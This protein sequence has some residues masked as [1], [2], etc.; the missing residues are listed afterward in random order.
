MGKFVECYLKQDHF[1]VNP[2]RFC[3]NG[4]HVGR[5]V[6]AGKTSVHTRNLLSLKIGL[7]YTL[8]DD[9]LHFMEQLP[10]WFGV[11]LSKW[12]SCSPCEV[13]TYHVTQVGLGTSHF[14]LL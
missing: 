9:I 7:F 8:T 5:D 11:C 1:L 3:G 12:V 14:Y 4:M 13:R 10:K 6:Y 2:S